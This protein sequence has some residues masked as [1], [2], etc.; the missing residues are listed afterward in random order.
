MDKKDTAQTTAKKI[1][2]VP[3]LK[4]WGSLQDITQGAP[5]SPTDSPSGSVGV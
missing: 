3:E 5:G 2:H 1:Y 4:E